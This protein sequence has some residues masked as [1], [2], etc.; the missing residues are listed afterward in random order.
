MGNLSRPVTRS[1]GVDPNAVPVPS[2]TAFGYTSST[3]TTEQ[4]CPP[5]TRTVPRTP[6]PEQTAAHHPADDTSAHAGDPD[7]SAAQEPSDTSAASGTVARTPSDVARLEESATAATGE[8]VPGYEI[9]GELGRGGMGVVYKARH[10]KLNRL[11]A[12]K[13]MR[14][15]GRVGRSD[16]IRFL[17]EAEAVAAI[18]HDN[19]VQVFDY[20]DADGRPFMALEFLPGGS[21]SAL[22]AKGRESV[23]STASARD[24]AAILSH[25]ARGVA[26]AHALGIVH[27]DLKP[28]NVLLDEGGTPKVADFGLAKR[29][30]GSEVTQTGQVMGTPAYMS[31]EQAKG[32]GPHERHTR[33]SE[34]GRCGREGRAARCARKERVGRRPPQGRQV[35]AVEYP[36]SRGEGRGRGKGRAQRQD[37]LLPLR[38]G[39]RCLK[40]ADELKKLGYD[41]RPLKEGYKDLLKAGFAPADPPK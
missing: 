8:G 11:V 17:A 2:G 37:R 21:L 22:L 39:V 34:E 5:K 35:A 6:A 27:R 29:G 14:G 9:L 10:L 40:A 12:L 38:S 41:V 20:G 33:G 24:T 16:L 7:R 19:V 3:F 1:V 4:P 31:P 18:T 23:S 28:A 15:G 26:A 30:D 36:Q 13:L 32:G 25:V